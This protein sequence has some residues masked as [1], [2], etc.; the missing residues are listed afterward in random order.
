MSV[1]SCVRRLCS[2]TRETTTRAR[3]KYRNNNFILYKEMLWDFLICSVRTMTPG[4]IHVVVDNRYSKK[5]IL[6]DSLYRLE[7]PYTAC[8]MK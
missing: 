7:P 2:S 5:G 8:N 3:L 1:R 6:L 4:S